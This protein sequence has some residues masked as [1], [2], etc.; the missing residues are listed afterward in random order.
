MSRKLPL[1]PRLGVSVPEGHACISPTINKDFPE[2]GS[3]MQVKVCPLHGDRKL[4]QDFNSWRANACISIPTFRCSECGTHNLDG[5]VYCWRCGTRAEPHSDLSASLAPD[6]DR[7]IAT[8][9]GQPASLVSHQPRSDTNRNR[10]QQARSGR[11]E[12]SG[13]AVVKGQ[14]TKLLR[15]A[16]NAGLVLEDTMSENAFTACS[17]A[18][19]GIT[20]SSIEMVA[21]IAHMKIANLG[22]TRA[23]IERG[24][25]Y[26]V[27]AKLCY[28]VPDDAQQINETE[29]YVAFMDRFYT[30]PE[31]AIMALA[32]NRSGSGPFT[33]LG[34]RER[35]D[36]RVGFGPSDYDGSAPHICRSASP[37][38]VRNSTHF[39]RVCDSAGAEHPGRV[40][41]FG[42][43]AAQ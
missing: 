40:R 6:R 26:E 36:T 30:V 15:K 12:S 1:T 7:H 17:H 31:T 18:R 5:S 13:P 10:A 14:A 42:R 37:T 43:Q 24:S 3:R 41:R 39:A 4:W 38:C 33:I 25:G 11:A 34:L 9:T 22:R 35:R 2:L 27:D 21:K 19:F 23:M 29:V 16:N 20:I 28:S 32:V 8:L